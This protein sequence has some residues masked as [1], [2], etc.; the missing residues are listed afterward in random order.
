MP[1]ITTDSLTRTFDDVIAVNKVDL[2]IPAAKVTGL[3]G[4]NGSGKST[5]IRTL[6]GLIAPT[7]GSASVLSN[8]ISNPAS[9]A[10]RVGALIEAPAFIA[11]MS[12]RANLRTLALLRGLPTSR[13]DEVLRV[14]GLDGRDGDRV[15]GYSLGMKQRLAIACAL[16]PD[17]ELLILDEPTN[18]LD[19]SGIVEIRQLLIELGRQGRTVVVSSHLMS[20]IQAAC[21][22]LVVIRHGDVLFQG[23]IGEMLRTHRPHVTVA[24]DDP[25]RAPDLLAAIE[26]SGL[27][28]NQAEDR[29]V[30]DLAP[31]RAADLFRLAQRADIALRLLQPVE[32]DLE[33]AFLAMTTQPPEHD[34]SQEIPSP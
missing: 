2:E 7:S 30:V 21:Q 31:D 25:T 13:I 4:P 22:H 1:A 17:P 33:A 11:S 20:E 3:V 10:D 16:L 5:L 26:G 32:A 28:V 12:A 19:P 6:L 9:Y 29:L 24:P 8:P 27:V 15:S 23:S 34:L 18:G 14:V